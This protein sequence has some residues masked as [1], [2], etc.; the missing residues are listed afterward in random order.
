MGRRDCPIVLF[1]GST[2][3]W[4]A[5][6]NSFDRFRELI[7]MGGLARL[8][9]ELPGIDWGRFRILLFEDHE[10]VGKQDYITFLTV[11]EA[12]ANRRD[13]RTRRR[14]SGNINLRLETKK[15]HFT[16]RFLA[17]NNLVGSY[18]QDRPVTAR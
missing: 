5:T 7:A 16:C 6:E 12:N 13:I 3:N 9:S 11:D 15:P 18:R 1:A 2:L 17:K 4:P 10:T 14:D 8:K